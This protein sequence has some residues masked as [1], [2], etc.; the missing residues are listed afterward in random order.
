LILLFK[1]TFNGF[2]RS[3]KLRHFCFN[4]GPYCAGVFYRLYFSYLKEKICGLGTP[5]KVIR[6]LAIFGSFSIGL[7]YLLIGLAAGMSFFGESEDAADEERI[8]NQIIEIP[9]GEAIIALIIAG[10]IGYI[11]WRVFEAFADPYEFGSD[12]KGIA[13]RAGIG[14]SAV[15]Y[16][17]IAFSAGDILL[18]G[19]D[20]GGE[21]ERQLLISQVLE[22]PGGQWIIGF[23]GAVTGLAG[24]VQFKYVIGGEY[25]KRIKM[26]ELSKS[27]GLTTRI[28][29]WAGYLARGIILLVLGFFLL[30]AAVNFDPEAA[31]DT[32]SAFDFLWDFGM[33]GKVVFL[34][35]A[36]GTVSYGFF[37]FIHGI[38]Y[39][40]EKG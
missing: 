38:F 40:F 20:E 21:E 31:G 18:Q 27:L 12:F 24:L 13:K 33:V 26:D 3:N 6:N 34:L 11:I 35:V 8:I 25:L 29:A 1:S 2:W 16:V 19:G 22:W 39:K 32:D 4:E 36:A 7:V 30:K 10:M 37:M 23:I 14:L 5:G 17:I 15:G 9:M 28:L